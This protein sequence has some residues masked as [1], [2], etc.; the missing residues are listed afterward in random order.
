MQ[1]LTAGLLL[2]GLVGLV[3]GAELLVRG[4]SCLAIAVGISPLVIGLTVVAYGTSAPEF[5][6]SVK[7]AFSNNIDIAI[8]NVVGSNIFNVLFILGVAALIIPLVVSQQLIRIDVPIMI[9]A[10]AVTWLFGLDGRIGRLEGIVFVL[11]AVAYTVF[12]IIQSRKETQAIQDEYQ[13]AFGGQPERSLGKIFLDIGL[14]LAGL[15]LLVLGARA[16]VDAAIVIA[17]NSGVSELVIGLTIVAVGT[18]LPEVAT[19]IT[20][21]LKGERDIAVGNVIGSNIFNILA[22]LGASSI[23]SPDGLAVSN[24]A[25]NFDIPVMLGVALACL[26]IFFTGNRI[27]RWEGFLFLAY[28]L[29]Y[30]VYLLLDTTEHSAIQYLILA[31]AAFLLP[32][33]GI[34]LL[35]SLWHSLKS[36]RKT[37]E[38]SISES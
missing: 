19:S 36:R 28:Y 25:S 2:V 5:A 34:S 17:R 8:G 7:S 26:P 16:L 1:L 11:A 33:T 24:A 30:T 9:G 6:V 32:L 3:A 14:I 10:S 15:V 13:E 18:S 35:V 23:V 29:V 31:V 22:V 38:S 20:A 12:L 4:A 27:D 37:S 21:T